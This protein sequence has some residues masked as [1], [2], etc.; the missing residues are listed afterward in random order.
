MRLAPV[1]IHGGQWE[2]K[3]YRGQG[4]AVPA[5]KVYRSNKFGRVV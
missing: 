2:G 1:F 3:Q 4:L 5:M